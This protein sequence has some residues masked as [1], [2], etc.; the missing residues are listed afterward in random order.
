MSEPVDVCGARPMDAPV[1]DAIGSPAPVGVRHLPLERT[2][3]VE[4][5]FG[6]RGRRERHRDAFANQRR[7]GQAFGRSD[8][9]E[10]AEL[11]VWSPSAPVR[12]LRLPTII[13][14]FGDQGRHILGTGGRASGGDQ[15]S[16]GGAREEQEGRGGN[17]AEALGSTS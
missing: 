8:Q 10:G 17:N 4:G 6:S 1:G 7:R 15:G 16:R 14:G 13:L 3:I 2:G 9:I 11:V 5:P 12:E